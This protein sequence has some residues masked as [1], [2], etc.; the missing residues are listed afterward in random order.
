MLNASAKQIAMPAL[1]I[2]PN[3]PIMLT[4]FLL[5]VDVRTSPA[6]V[7]RTGQQK[8]LV[9]VPRLARQELPDRRPLNKTETLPTTMA[10]RWPPKTKAHERLQGEDGEEHAGGTDGASVPVKFDKPRAAVTTLAT[11]VD[12]LDIFEQVRRER[13]EE[14]TSEAS[15]IS[16]PPLS[17]MATILGKCY[18]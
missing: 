2:D 12:M 3:V 10:T 8:A 15:I 6:T 13:D 11:A 14:G 16:V 5:D 18:S 9:V 17:P 4:Q 1:H 7:K